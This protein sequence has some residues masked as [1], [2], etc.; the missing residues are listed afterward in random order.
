M[1]SWLLQVELVEVRGLVQSPQ[2]SARATGLRKGFVNW[3]HP[4][5]FSLPPPAPSVPV[6]PSLNFLTHNK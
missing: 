1:W 2:H 6:N 3:K 5:T 4:I